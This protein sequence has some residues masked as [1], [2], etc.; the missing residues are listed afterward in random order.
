MAKIDEVALRNDIRKYMK[1]YAETYCKEAAKEITKMAGEAINQFY[2][3]YTPDY[4]NRT[5]DLKYNSYSPYYHN[6]GRVVYGGVRINSDR[7]RDYIHGNQITSAFDVASWTWLHGYHGHRG[8][9][10]NIYT[11]PP[12]TI[13]QMGMYDPKFLQR[14]QDT[15]EKSAKNQTYRTIKF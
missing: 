5:D 13:V 3:D 10:S 2:N 12:I 14:L 11:Y 15:G 6:N 1:T 7:M 9:G 8:N 4:Y